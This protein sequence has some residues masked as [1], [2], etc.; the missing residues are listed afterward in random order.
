MTTND[1][2]PATLHDRTPATSGDHISAAS[3]DPHRDELQRVLDARRAILDEARPG[4]V[5]RQHARG[6][7][8]AR[9]ALA[10]LADAGSFVEYGGLARPAVGDL[11]GPADGLVMGTAQVGGRPVDLVLYDYTVQGGTQS[12]INHIKMTRM[13]EHALR[14]RL[15][16]ICWLDGGG[17]RT[18]D[19]T[20]PARGPTPTFVV[21]ARLSGVAPTIGIVPSRAFAG[22][23]NLAGM[24]DLLIAVRGSAMGLAGPPLVEAALG[25]KLTPEEIGPADVHVRTGVIDLLADDDAHAADLARRYLSYFGPPA[26]P[27]QPP[28]PLPLRTLVPEN[29]RRAYDVRKVVQHLA[30]VGSMLELKAGFGKSVVTALMRLEGRAVGVV[31][32]QPLH[33]AGAIDSAASVKAARFVQICDAY[34]IP[35]L[36]L[37]DTPGLLAG[38][39]AEKTGLV[40]H[41]GRMLSA[42]ANATTPMMTVVL[43][44]AYGLGYYIMGSQPLEP[45]VLLAWPTAE[46]GG[47]GLEGAVTILHKRELE[48]IADPAQRAERHRALTGQLKREHAAVEAAGKYVYDDVIDPVD[49]R[50]LL[51]RTLATLPAAPM[52]TERKRVIEPF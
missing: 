13:F 3:G 47:M 23:A 31:A 42:I 21:F 32:N 39:E 17:A 26:A 16:V 2:T 51:L 52:R 45:A 9:E 10:A 1:R 43:R 12:A 8:T 28:D 15:P 35:L 25:V 18:H 33:L 24:C 48:A 27:G 40:R 50:A 19:M 36:L 11:D 34:D 38:P 6:R 7:L 41:S 37:C 20:V 5:A 30:D 4:A 29:P 46:Y 22:H 49:T 14:H 44:K